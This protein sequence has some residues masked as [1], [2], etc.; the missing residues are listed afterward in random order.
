[1]QLI[2]MY[3]RWKQFIFWYYNVKDIEFF[4]KSVIFRCF[5]YFQPQN[6]ENRKYRLE[7]PVFAQI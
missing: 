5:L 4:Q 1:M 7:I 2:Y 3:V 6:V